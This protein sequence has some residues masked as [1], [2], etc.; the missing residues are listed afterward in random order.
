MRFKSLRDL[1]KTQLV[2]AIGRTTWKR[3]Q[4]GKA[5]N[6]PIEV[7]TGSDVETRSLFPAKKM[8]LAQSRSSRLLVTSDTE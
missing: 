4:K 8:P 6:A 1:L 3:K 5:I 2:A 7:K